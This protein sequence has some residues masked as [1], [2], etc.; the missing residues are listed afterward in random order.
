MPIDRARLD[1]AFNPKAIAVVGAKRSANYSWLRNMQTFKGRLYSV[2]I[3]P[4]EIPG[5]EELGIANYLHVTD[6]PDQV[7]YAVIAVPRRVVPAVL[8]ECI[9]KGVKTVHV[10]ASGFAESGTPDGIEAQERIT[11]MA[12]ESGTLLLGPNCMGVFNPAMGMRFNT[13]QRVGVPGAV[14][15][16]AQSGGH[17]GS[18]TQAAEA[19]GI[20]VNKTVSF[21]NAALI[22]ST[23]LLEYFSEDD[24]TRVIV[25][26]VEGPRDGHRFFQVLRS[27]AQ[28]KPVVVWKGGQTE[29]GRRAVA[30]HTGALAGSADLW[31]IALRQAGAVPAHSLEEALDATK[32]LLHLPRSTGVGVGII[33]GTGGQSV[34]MTDAFARHGLRVPRL[35]PPSLQRLAEF[36]QLVGASYFNPMDVGGL[37]RSMLE[38]IVEILFADSEVSAVVV[39][40]GAGVLR[41]NREEGLA[42]LD[43]YRRAR[44][45]TGKPLLAIFN[46]A[47]PYRDGAL[48]DELE[49]VLQGMSVPSFPSADRAAL[50]LG[51]FVNYHRVV[52]S[53]GA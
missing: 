49:R 29:D 43:L 9:Q 37:N 18:L 11:K 34:S 31:G 13:E 33:G 52:A 51:R 46:S 2:Q 16:I 32:A 30:S 45:R 23:D 27:T 7:D 4:T 10:F 44:D 24:S 19:S 26:Y 48:L 15:F 25:L 28:R 50:A 36:F 39:Q 53:D 8:G 6:I 22:D 1:E 40:L 17:A 3:D 47:N 38:T 20:A 42:Q 14:A 5:I 41:G 35:S 12:E 21:G